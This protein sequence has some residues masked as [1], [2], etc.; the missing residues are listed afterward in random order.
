MTDNPGKQFEELTKENFE[1]FGICYD[2]IHD[3]V[4]GLLGSDNVCDF[5]VY[6]YPHLFY[7]ECK[8]T[9]DVK[10]DM[11]H[12]IRQYQWIKLLKKDKYPGVRA[13][14]LIWMTH[15]HRLFWV[16]S[17]KAKYYYEAGHKTLSIKD[18]ETIGVEI[19]ARKVR[20]KWKFD[21]IIE[22]IKK[23]SSTV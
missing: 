21:N 5:D 8:E 16:T 20:D 1:Q 11:L 9:K 4:S 6:D 2:R 19:P 14:Y 17:C 15:Y 10:F 3:Q 23:S 13:G 18:L 12:N 7:I 22:C